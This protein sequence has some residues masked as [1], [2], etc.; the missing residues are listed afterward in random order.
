M[1]LTAQQKITVQTFV[2]TTGASEKVA[3]RVSDVAMA[4]YTY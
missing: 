2:T 1:P 4:L 3:Q